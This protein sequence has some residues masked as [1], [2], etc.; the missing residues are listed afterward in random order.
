MVKVFLQAS[1]SPVRQIWRSCN[2]QKE[3]VGEGLHSTEAHW[4]VICPF[5]QQYFYRNFKAYLLLNSCIISR[6]IVLCFLHNL[7]DF[8]IIVVPCLSLFTN[9]VET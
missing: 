9:F 6:I 1:Q 4:L 8:H 3:Q 5:R 2:H 7:V